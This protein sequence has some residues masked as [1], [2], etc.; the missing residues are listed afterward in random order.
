MIVP[1]ENATL[2]SVLES[3]YAPFLDDITSSATQLLSRIDSTAPS[4]LNL[5]SIMLYPGT[6]NRLQA[7]WMASAPQGFAKLL[8]NT[9]YEDFT[10]N[11]YFF[12][13]ITIHKLHLQDRYLFAAQLH[14]LLLLSESSLGIEDAIRA[15][16]GE[17]PRLDFEKSPPKPGHIVLNT[18][19]L[20]RWIQQLAK[21]GYH[22]IIQYSMKGTQ[23]ALLTLNREGEQQNREFRFTG[24][25]ALTDSIPSNLVAAFSGSN[26]PITLDRYI[27]SNA[28][29]FGIFRREPR[30]A[31]PTALTDTTPLDTFLMNNKVQYADIAK[32]LNK[33]FALVLYAESGFLSTGEHL[34]L[35]K[36]SDISTLRSELANLADEGLIERSDGTY[37]IQSSVL[38]ELIGSSLCSFQDFYLDITG[39]V[40]VISERKGLAEIVS[41]DHNRRRTIYYEDEFRNIKQG[42]PD[43]LSGLFFLN[44]EFYSFIKPFLSPENYVNAFTSKFDLL[45]V[46][47]RLNEDGNSLSFTLNTYQTEE[48][49]APY[50]EKWVFPTGAELSGEPVLADIGG[51]SREEVIFATKSGHVYALAADGTMVMQASTDSD[52]PIGSPV[53]YDWYATNEN[54][55]LLAAGNKIYGWDDTGQP[56]PK[57]PFEMSEAITAPLVVGDVNRDGLPNA[58]VATANRNLHVLSGRGENIIGWPV[59]TNAVVTT[60]PVV[61]NYMGSLSVLAFSQ[62][63]VHAWNQTGRPKQ[64]FPKFISASLNGS[65]MVYD[66]HILANAADGYLYSIGS[67]KMFA[68]SLN[69][70]EITS[71]S[72]NIEAIYASN[73]P[74]VGTPSVRQLAAYGQPV[75]LTV[76]SNGSVFLLDTSGQ[77]RFTENM[78]QPAAPFFSP[79]VDDINRDGQNEIIALAD[80]GRLY[81][82]QVRDGERIY[83]VPTSSMEYPIIAD[84]DN[85]GWDELIAQTNEGVRCWTIYGRLQ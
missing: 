22:P 47:T 53:V 59:T 26:A 72:S 19:S 18:P 74:L 25:I 60:K 54:V 34:F 41:S 55:I 61:E 7:V 84:I 40:V 24:T 42:L 43:Q 64:G 21:V 12:H 20:D 66:E 45:A 52:E 80:Y 77:L 75:I 8:K 51:S 85:D 37:Y 3:P 57:F 29:A 6:T 27:S 68:D 48:Q 15:Y 5:Q 50:R 31:P 79:F 44:A 14:D 83:S 70:F 56:L 76:S 82:W 62:N 30:M 9:F 78:G 73:S 46:A 16:R 65:P 10:Q 36:V 71:D 69:V 23:P 81:A 32:T 1:A 33:E 63:A 58:I 11:Q 13:D 2:N 35:R 28:A 4:P 38:S 17:L 49:D 39:D 67:K